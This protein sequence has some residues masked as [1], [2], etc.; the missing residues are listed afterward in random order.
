MYKH[1]NMKS[2]NYDD[3][4]IKYKSKYINLKLKQIN[5]PSLINSGSIDFKSHGS[6]NKNLF[7]HKD[8]ID[9]SSLIVTKEGSYSITGKDDGLK[10]LS[11]IKSIVKEDIKNLSITDLTGNIGGDTIMF[12]LNFKT[13]YSIE[14]DKENFEALQNNVSIF[15][16]TNVKLFNGDSTKIFYEMDK[17][18]NWYTDVL[19]IDPPWGGPDY[20]NKENLNLYLGDKRLDIYLASLIKNVNIKYIFL[21]LPRNYNWKAL[22]KIFGYV[23]RES[24]TYNV[25]KHKIRGYIIMSIVK[26]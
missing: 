10:L 5:E 14:L 25:I 7:A 11:I 9:Y 3:L 23:N 15:G 26:S 20:K 24:S 16:L 8:N 19:Y 12:G 18:S 1:K 21:K 2:K 17:K 6:N 13:V 4:Y 22:Y